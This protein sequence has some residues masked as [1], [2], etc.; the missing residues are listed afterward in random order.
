[1]RSKFVAVLAAFAVL[2]ATGAEAARSTIPLSQARM[3]ALLDGIDNP[4]LGDLI[5]AGA[6]E[7]AISFVPGGGAFQKI[8]RSVVKYAKFVRRKYPYTSFDCFQADRIGVAVDHANQHIGVYK[9]YEALL[10]YGL[11]PVESSECK[12]EVRKEI[13]ERRGWTDATKA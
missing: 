9:D 13:Y 5:A 2:L 3:D 8:S 4:G 12:A 10:S 11:C 6:C 1:M 7:I